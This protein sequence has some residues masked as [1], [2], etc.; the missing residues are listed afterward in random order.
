MY[1]NVWAEQPLSDGKTIGG[2]RRLT[3]AAINEIQN[4]YGLAIGKNVISLVTMRKAVWAE[5][6]HLSSD[7]ESP[8][9]G[10]CPKG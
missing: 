6:F 8:T 5:Y 10:L 2:R 1:K 7:N 9:R 3:S 4:Y